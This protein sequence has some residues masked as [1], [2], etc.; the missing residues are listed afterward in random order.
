MLVEG[1]DE[2]GFIGTGAAPQKSDDV[3]LMLYTDFK[4][5]EPNL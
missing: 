2:N 1:L 3:Y 4:S 5:F